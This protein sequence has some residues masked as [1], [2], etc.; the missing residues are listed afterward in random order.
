MKIKST[1]ITQMSGSI[2]GLTGS[3]NKGGLYFRARS[4]PVNPGSTQQNAIRALVA[5]LSNLWNSEVTEAKRLEWATYADAVLLPSP[6]GD[7]RAVTALNH[8]VRSNVPRL[9]AALTRQDTAPAEFNIGE[10]TSPTV[11]ASAS[12]DTA[13]VAFTNTD[14]WA[15]EAGSSMLVW[16]SRP[17]A[18]TINHF[19]GPYRYAGKVNGATPTPPTSPATITLPFPVTAG[20]KLFF[21]FNV[22]RADGRLSAPFRTA[23]VAS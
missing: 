9:Q 6:L 14:D 16:I 19:T 21:R 20:Q 18:D 5:Q 12:A 11:T 17:Q 15:A 13:S 2:G 3:H 7:Q 4:I 1:L 8:Y 10:Y 22:T 23:A